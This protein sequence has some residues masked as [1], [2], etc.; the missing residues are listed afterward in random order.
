MKSGPTS[1]SRTGR[2]EVIFSSS[3]RFVE[4]VSLALKYVPP[5]IAA[6]GEEAPFDRFETG[7]NI[8]V[9]I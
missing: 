8:F 9:L 4:R 1:C 7:E 3:G 2:I 5:F 6:M